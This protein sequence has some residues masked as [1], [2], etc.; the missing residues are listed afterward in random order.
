MRAFLTMLGIII[1]IAAVIAILTVGNSL[2]RSV[3]E[4]MQ[5][6]GANDVF[7]TVAQR[8]DEE[9]ETS[10]SSSALDGIH[11]GSFARSS[12]MTDDDY[13]T[14]D[15]I[16]AMYE[17][18]ADDIYAINIS[19]T[20]GSA[21]LQN[22]EK[23]SGVSL[24]GVSV[25]Y[26]VTNS[27]EMV[28]GSMFNDLDFS[29]ERKTILVS[30]DTAE[31]LFG[32]NVKD[33]VGQDIECEVDGKSVIVTIAGVYKQNQGGGNSS[34]MMTSMLGGSSAYMP[35][36]AAMNIDHSEDQYTYFQVSA[37]ADSD[38]QALADK[39]RDFY[40]PYY[41]NNSD[42]RVSVITYE[43]LLEMFYT[44]LGTITTAIS[45][46]AGIALLVGGI[47]V[48]NIM[49]VSVTERTREIGTRKALGARNSSIR[50]QFIVEAMIICLIGGAFGVVL[51]IGLGA[52]ASN[53]LGYPAKPSI[54]GI[55]IA[56]L[57][58]MS[59]GLFFGYFPANK[60]AKMNP[61]DALRYE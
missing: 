52:F 60:A 59:I 20:V 21:S 36:R 10:N 45:I 56:L 35:L 31:D 44:L 30:V 26:F 12:E 17:Q 57:F 8:S 11:Y 33:A 53:L 51:G 24:M 54:P 2:N 37:K 46:I 25:G 42:Y 6:M 19:H 28:E 9:E 27:V 38:P 32:E 48:M 7:V 39:I 16:R 40:K 18:Y 14:G 22:G 49:L 29:E 5:S 3:A 4:T 50:A 55:I 13:I 43:S 41:R 23:E 47:G 34:M 58:S 1:G 15:M 61:I